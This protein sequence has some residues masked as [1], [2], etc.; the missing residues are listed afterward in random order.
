ML[1]K[2][3][4]FCNLDD[5]SIY[6]GKYVTLIKSRFPVVKKGH[7]LIVPKR[8]IESCYDL[9]NK[10]WVDVIDTLRM[11]KYRYLSYKDDIT[12]TNVGFNDGKLAGQTIMHA[13]IHVIKRIRGDVK[14]PSGGIRNIIP[15]KGSYERR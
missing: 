13:H 14:N 1:K 11:I 6:N 12:S 7:W 8:H 4:R 15:G 9:N 3:C 10:E 2:V 5:K